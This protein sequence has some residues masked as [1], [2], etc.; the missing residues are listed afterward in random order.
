MRLALFGGS[1]NPIHIAHIKIAKYVLEELDYNKILFMPAFV[2]PFKTSSA[3]LLAPP[4]DRLCMVRLATED[5]PLFETSD[6]EILQCRC[7]FTIDTI[8]HLYYEYET[9]KDGIKDNKKNSIEGK[10]GLII[11]SD[12]LKELKK[13]KDFSTLASLCDIIVA[14]RGMEHIGTPEDIPLTHIKGKVPN[15]SS[16]LIRDA[17]KKGDEWTSYVPQKVAQYIEENALYSLE[18]KDIEVLIARISSYA[19]KVLSEERFLHSIAVG[20][21]GERL[22]REYP[23]LQV[24][25]R[26]AYLAG[27]SHDITKEETDEWQ[28]SI[29]RSAG[30][31]IED[32]AERKR[33]NLLHGRTASIIL[34]ERF[35]INHRSLL[36][37]IKYHTFSHPDLD[38]LGKILYIADKIAEGRDGVGDFR[39]MI[40][41]SSIDEIMY[42]LLE[43]S[44]L[45]LKE[46]G[47][48]PHI[49][50]SQLLLKLKKV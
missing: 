47:L 34:K 17:I 49:Y 2:S 29:L 26:L 30:E 7:S 20:K 23:S 9:K 11:G 42:S 1:F 4:N 22:A 41:N 18:L 14:K 15:I 32:D 19:K 40:G 31:D 39:A 38:N 50:A 3:S 35:S 5:T 28:L 45:K 6:Y 44:E 33:P 43:R 8:K 46:K 37:A 13:W 10:I 21:M 12:N 16:T 27:I 24:S 25:L 36:A 48:S